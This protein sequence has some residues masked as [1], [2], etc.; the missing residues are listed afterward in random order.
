LIRQSPPTIVGAYLRGLFEAD[1]ALSHGYPSLMTT[2]SQLAR[3]VATLLI[4]LGCPVNIR[5]ISPG[6]DHW[7]DAQTFQV[8][9][10]STVGLQAWREKIGC[11]QRSRFVAAHA[12]E[13][14]LRKPPMYC[15]MQNAGSASI[16]RNHAGTDRQTGTWGIS[17]SCYG[18]VATTNL[19]YY[20]E[21]RNLTCSDSDL[22]KAEHPEAFEN[23]NDRWFVFCGSRRG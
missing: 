22:L 11:D 17:I 1:G 23:A 5:K 2:S 6:I 16:G 8:R 15:Q 7:G 13:S 10:T 12:W 4:G 9:I 21:D 14:D 3:E 20:R 18:T 19:R